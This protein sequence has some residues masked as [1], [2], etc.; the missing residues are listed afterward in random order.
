MLPYL[1]PNDPGPGIRSFHSLSLGY[2]V[3]R[4]WR[5]PNFSD[6]RIMLPLDSPR[7]TELKHAYGDAADIPRL[8]KE[9]ENFPLDQGPL[10]N[11]PWHSVW[12]ALAHQGDVYP[13]SFAAVPWIVHFLGVD[14]LKSGWEYFGFP[15]CVEI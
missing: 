8:L 2:N 12:S 7:W 11:G 5:R 3:G 10:F 4:R 6:F 9:L 14:P 1:S 15:A 13:A